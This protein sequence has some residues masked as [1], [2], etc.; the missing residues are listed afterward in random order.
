MSV[1]AGWSLP[2]LT[3]DTGAAVRLLDFT[4]W[5]RQNED[6]GSGFRPRPTALS[7]NFNQEASQ[8]YIYATGCAK[9]AF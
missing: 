5:S 2:S 3:S 9:E 7:S 4:L 8:S 1:W 6:L